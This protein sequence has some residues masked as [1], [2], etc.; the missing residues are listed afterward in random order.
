MTKDDFPTSARG[1]FLQ[2]ESS[3][4]VVVHCRLSKSL[5][6]TLVHNVLLSCFSAVKDE[7]LANH[8]N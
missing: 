6:V 3:L 8:S 5:G 7:N 1:T 4:V 2:V